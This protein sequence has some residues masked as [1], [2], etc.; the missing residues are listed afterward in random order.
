[1]HNKNGSEKIQREQA[2]QLVIFASGAGS[3]A[4]R[5]I[6][7]FK[8]TAAFNIALIVCNKP[9]AGVIAVAQRENIPVLLIEKERFFRGDGYLPE[10]IR[11]KTSLIVLAGFLWKIPHSLIEA[12]PRKIINI[13]PALLPSHGGKGM[14]GQLVHEAVLASGDLQSGITVHYVDEHYDNGDIIFQ[15]ACPVL[16]GDT[17]ETLAARIHQ[18][19]HLYYPQVIEGLLNG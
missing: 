17:A 4:D 18:L 11:I 8:N 6:Q 10:F 2:H 16:P 7:Y 5:I 19:E 15:T 14:Y 3:N 9:G 1:Q 12:F 13:H